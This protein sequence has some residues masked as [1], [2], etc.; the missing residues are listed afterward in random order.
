[1]RARCHPALQ[2]A[3]RDVEQEHEPVVATLAHIDDDLFRMRNIYV[4]AG[5]LS[6]RFLGSCT[7]KQQ[8]AVTT[9]ELTELNRNNSN[10]L[11]EKSIFD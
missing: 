5:I 8:R 7:A 2:S 3:L 4:A 11:K 6:R 1:L 9:S 10:G